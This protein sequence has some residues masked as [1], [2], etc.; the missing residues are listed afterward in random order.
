M[1]GTLKYSYILI[2]LG[3]GCASTGNNPI[4]NRTPSSANKYSL[5][6]DGDVD[7]LTPT[8]LDRRKSVAKKITPANLQTVTLSF[9]QVSE[10]MGIPQS[11]LA[12]QAKLLANFLD[13][14]HMP[15]TLCNE[16]TDEN[17]EKLCT[18]I[19]EIR[20]AQSKG[21]S[22]RLIS[23]GRRVP[24]RPHHFFQQQ[25]MGFGRLMK[26]I[27]REPATRILEWAPR[28]LASTG[29]PR[30][31]S[32]V[33]IRK[34]EG[35]LPAPA[36]KKMMERLYEHASAC[37]RAEDEGFETTHFRQALLRQSWGDNAGALK[38]IDRAILAK[39]S[40][41]R[42]RVLYWAGMF[43]TDKRKQQAHWNRLVEDYPLSFHALEVWQKR[44]MDPYSIFSTRPQLSL[45]RRTLGADVQVDNS[46]RWLES[47]YLVGRV[48]AAQKMTRWLTRTYKEKL[49]AQNLLYVSLLKSSRGTPLN[50]I[51]F[52]T[53]QVADNPMILNHQTLS[54]L[55]PRPY[56]ETFERVSP[57][58]DSFLLLSVARQESGFNPRAR[59]SANARGLLQLLPS[60]ARVL[61][62]RRSV[63]L[64]DS[65]INATLGAKFLGQLIDQFESV[66][67]A[68]AAYNAGPGRIPEWKQRYGFS[69]LA[70][71]LDLIPF[72]ET[73]NYVSSI[74]RNNYWYERLYR[75]PDV[76]MLGY[77]KR[78]SKVVNRLVSAHSDS[79]A[80]AIRMPASEN[81]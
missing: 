64:Y 73:R 81:L 13:R 55:F 69:D 8:P 26:S 24:I 80:E 44:D 56:M 74:L 77:T 10:E 68:L 70:L 37:L 16:D 57:S 60:T 43:Q 53:R 4:D 79:S 36:A 51:T 1:G 50:T 58:T 29:C 17:A 75:S 27:H 35:L 47:L 34:I 66:E 3:A 49:T 67:L 61:A 6:Q 22:S 38:S 39:D 32:A 33:S 45:N 65:E 63:N 2:L 59:S 72:K 52:L 30:N 31:L 71:F 23:P 42:S 12:L 5:Y 9:G 62:G 11:R 48:E 21:A 15:S 78:R 25:A 76:D 41:E 46:L 18:M 19:E 7:V 20:A 28:M 40:D 54:I 14:R